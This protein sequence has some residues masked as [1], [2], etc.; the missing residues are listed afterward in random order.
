MRGSLYP[1][2]EIRYQICRFVLNPM[3]YS[4]ALGAFDMERSVEEVSH[5]RHKVLTSKLELVSSAWLDLLCKYVNH[6]S[7]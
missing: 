6:I 4:G 2:P 1:I 5:G 3:C 7:V